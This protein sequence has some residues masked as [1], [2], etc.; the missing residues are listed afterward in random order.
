MNNFEKPSQ[1]EKEPTILEEIEQ[2]IKNAPARIEKEYAQT[3]NPW[4]ACIGTTLFQLETYIHIGSLVKE[5][6]EERVQKMRQK[7]EELKTF[8]S[9]I[10]DEYPDKSPN[11]PD[12]VQQEF[13][14]RL[15]DVLK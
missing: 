13:Y 7:S 12:E 11:P 2:V 14:N 10:A 8:R 6:G 15:N 1:P 5:I 4:Y 3:S 9:R